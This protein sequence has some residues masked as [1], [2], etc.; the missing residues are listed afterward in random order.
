VAAIAHSRDAPCEPLAVPQHGALQASGDPFEPFRLLDV[1]SSGS[2]SCVRTAGRVG[3]AARPGHRSPVTGHRRPDVHQTAVGAYR[4]EVDVAGMDQLSHPAPRIPGGDARRSTIGGR[5]RADRVMR[6]GRRATTDSATVCARRP[7]CR[8]APR[9][10]IRRL[11]QVLNQHRSD[12]TACEVGGPH[13]RLSRRTEPAT[14]ERWTPPPRPVRRR[15]PGRRS[16]CAP[17]CAGRR[18]CAAAPWRL[19]R[20][21]LSPPLLPRGSAQRPGGWRPALVT[22]PLPP[23]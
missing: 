19:Q 9:H 5:R 3:R 17:S 20:S 7:R 2:R 15:V 10:R 1:R 12:R 16:G 18:P 23:S 8:A 13:R 11:V 4:V 21:G 22:Q 14:P 6:P